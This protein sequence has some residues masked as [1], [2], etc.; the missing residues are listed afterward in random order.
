LLDEH[1][2]RRAAR[3]RV[4]VLFSLDGGPAVMA[5]QRPP[6]RP[7]DGIGGTIESNLAG[8]VAS[9]IPYFVN[10]VATPGH[11]ADLPQRI[12]YLAD[13]G[14]TTVQLCYA[15]GPG[16][17]AARRAEF[18]RALASCVALAEKCDPPLRIQNLGARAE[19]TVL[20]N[21]LLVDVDGVLY[22]D[23]AIF[24]EGALPGLRDAYRIGHVDE[25]SSFDGLRRDRGQN[26]GI[27]RG[28]YPPGTPIRRRLERHLALGREVQATLDRLAS[29]TRRPPLERDSNPLLNR[30]LGGSLAEQQ[31]W[32]RRRP[33][34]LALPLLHL[35][36]RC[37]YDCIFCRNKEL[38]DTPKARA[39]SWLEGNESAGLS[40]LGLVGNEPLAHPDIDA[41]VD[42]ALR[43]GF[44]RLE[45]MTTAAP[46]A[47]RERLERW[48]DAGMDGFTIPLFGPDAATHDAI[49]RSPGSFRQT[50]EIL[51]H[52]VAT[53]ADVH[54]HANV[55]RQNLARLDE[56]ERVVADE[57][58]AH[59]CLIP[60]RPKA[61]NLPYYAL[62]P[63]Y[64]E[65][66][67]KL[68]VR[69]LVAFPRCVAARI[70]GEELP[71]AA[72]ISDLLKVYVLDQPFVQPACC[73][74]CAW[75]GSCVG[76]FEAH[77]AIHGEEELRAVGR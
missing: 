77:V 13:R 7:R 20:S 15:T 70:Q 52:L 5:R 50:R 55:L 2:L 67:E 51:E 41:I 63:S 4:R 14:V 21:D 58:G 53:G 29:R 39:L 8:L 23:A 48:R 9:G 72:I 25:L 22:G 57:L 73:R 36:N 37:E 56:L 11:C 26:L 33:E 65:L 34:V 17:T 68:S 3:H 12:A 43:H 1:F 32:M 61:A 64:A 16:W 42:G 60:V 62:A 44:R 31:R 35:I 54:V 19:P 38:E 66:I 24:A 74:G 40:R 28:R 27:L 49:T 75:R 46:L 10:V 30:L 76:T 18:C 71:D 47:D 6:A 45:V 59:F 69:S